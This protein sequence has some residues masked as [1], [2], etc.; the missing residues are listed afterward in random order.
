[1]AE[2]SG[3]ITTGD[4]SGTGIAVGAGARATV[5]I[6]QKTQEELTGLF[7]LLRAEVQKA[8]LSEGAKNVLLTKA[9]PEMEAAV[10]SPDPKPAIQRG[11][12]RID[13]QL[14]GVNAVAKDVVGIVG[15]VAKIAG[16]VGLAVKTVAPFVAG[17]L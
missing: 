2:Q 17:L 3:N 1:M 13:D 6:N 4:I 16:V 5:T 14:Q 15:T 10:R 8:N 12:E 7:Q 11:L 9:V